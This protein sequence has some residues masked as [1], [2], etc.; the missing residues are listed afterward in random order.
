MTV[1]P[2]QSDRKAMVAVFGNPDGNGDGTADLSWIAA[3]LVAIV[4]PYQLYY[5]G[6]PVK[7]ITV[8]KAIAPAVMRALT[9]VKALYPDPKVLAKL[10]IDRFDGCYNFRPKRGNAASLSTHAYAVGMDWSA[11]RNPFHAKKSDLPADFVK[12]FTDEGA[13]WGNTWSPASRDPMH[14]QFSRTH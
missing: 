9:K 8:N 3:H 4:P 13:E 14:I 6:K 10:G 5:A 11:A 1:W 7:T 2:L 12:A